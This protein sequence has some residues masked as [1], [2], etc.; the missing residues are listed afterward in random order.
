[1]MSTSRKRDTTPDVLT[2][3]LVDAFVEG[4]TF[5]TATQSGITNVDGRF[6]YIDGEMVTFSVG[7]IVLGTVAGAPLI[8]PVELSGAVSSI[9]Q[10]AINQL[11]FLQSIDEDQNL[12][13]GITITQATRDAAATQTLDFTLDSAAFTSAVAPVVTAI[14]SVNP[15]WSKYS[16]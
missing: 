8:S 16:R 14:T 2:G 3:V 9:D 4:V 15:A 1:M 7:G 11:V 6:A 13:N 10:V 5:E 12:L